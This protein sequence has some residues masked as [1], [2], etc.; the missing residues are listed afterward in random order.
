MK[1]NFVQEID[2]RLRKVWRST[3]SDTNLEYLVKVDRPH[4]DG[5]KLYLQ[6]AFELSP[7]KFNKD[8]LVVIRATSRSSNT[9]ISVQAGV[10][11]RDMTRQIKKL[12]ETPKHKEQGAGVG[13]DI[14]VTFSKFDVKPQYVS[15]VVTAMRPFE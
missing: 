2:N 13:P 9:G 3:H 14:S 4:S 5:T 1:S 7:D 11:Y 8:K 6:F 10:L 12:L 15:F